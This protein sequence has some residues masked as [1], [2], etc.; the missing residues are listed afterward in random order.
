MQQGY[1]KTSKMQLKILNDP[2]IIAQFKGKYAF[3]SNFWPCDIEIENIIYPSAEHAYQA[4]KSEHNSDRLII[5]MLSTAENA[6][7]LGKKVDLRKDWKWV[8]LPYMEQIVYNKFNQNVNLGIMLINTGN[9]KL[10]EGNYWNDSF[11]GIDLKT[12]EGQNHLGK[13]L[14]K[15]RDIL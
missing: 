11:W 8:K 6:K 10:M 14:T 7:I 15:T 4:M 13:I 3:L 9:K 12:G 1:P 5:K 2:N